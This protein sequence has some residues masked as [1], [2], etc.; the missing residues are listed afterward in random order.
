MVLIDA[1]RG[2]SEAL[3]ASAVP[4]EQPHVLLLSSLGAENVLGL[5]DLWLT[6]WLRG[7]ETP[8]VVYGPPGT[9]ALVDGLVR[10]LSAQADAQ[11]EAWSLPAA[12][13]EHRGARA[14]GRGEPRRGRALGPRR[15]AR[16]RPAAGP[17]LAHRGRRPQ[18]RDHRR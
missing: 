17:R 6:G 7:R 5:D 8:L 11:A 2:V 10:A 13:R 1:G 14:R 4:V 3:R 9:Q 16:R 12:G 15:A 18:R